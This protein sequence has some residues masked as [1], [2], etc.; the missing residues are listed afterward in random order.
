[1]REAI[2]RDEVWF[3]K[4]CSQGEQVDTNAI[5][6]RIRIEIGEQWLARKLNESENPQLT[7][8]IRAKVRE[9]IGNAS[10]E[11]AVAKESGNGHSTIHR[12]YWMGGS[13]IGM[14]AMLFLAFGNLLD[15]ATP[16]SIATQD[17][18]SSFVDAFEQ[19]EGDDWDTS[20]G[21]L[22][23][24]FDTLASAGSGEGSGS[25]DWGGE[26]SDGW[27]EANGNDNMTDG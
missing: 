16:I 4:L 15:P 7:N 24:E 11:V 12:L 9:S 23:D 22:S 25:D 26:D 3:G 10:S 1:M 5:K 20:F 19:Y 2:E 21:E 27:F 14:A 17:S 18:D 6:Q 8:R 13:A